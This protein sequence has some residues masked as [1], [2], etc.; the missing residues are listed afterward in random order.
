MF[1]RYSADWIHKEY[2]KTCQPH[3]FWSQVKRTVNGVPVGED[4]VALIERAITSGLQLKQNDYLL[5]LCCGNGALSTRI[6]QRCLG[7]LG[8]DFSEYLIDVAKNNFA[9][10]QQQY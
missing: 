1:K 2:P 3:D 9:N 8:V 7:G 4:Q 10:Q 5:D 6:F